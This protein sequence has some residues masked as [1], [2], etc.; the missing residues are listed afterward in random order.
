MGKAQPVQPSRAPL[1]LRACLRHQMDAQNAR[2]SAARRQLAPK[3]AENGAAGRCAP[4]KGRCE[5]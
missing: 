5:R 1:V 4:A 2:K 3:C